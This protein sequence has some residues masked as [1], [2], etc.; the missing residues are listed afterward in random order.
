MPRHLCDPAK[1][2][3]DAVIARGD[4]FTMPT[5]SFDKP[6][7]NPAIGAP[8]DQLVQQFVVQAATVPAGGTHHPTL[9]FGGRTPAG[10][11]PHWIYAGS[12]EQLRATATLV[13]DMAELAI[14]TADT[15]NG[16]RRG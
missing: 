12:D 16:G 14:R 6:M 11:L 10:V 4:S 2:F 8:G 15:A 7:T 9:V 13:H 3:L 1:A 5:L